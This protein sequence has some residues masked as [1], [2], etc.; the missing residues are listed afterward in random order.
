MSSNVI[1]KVARSWLGTPYRH[2]AHLKGVGTDC[3]GLIC[4]VWSELYGALPEPLPAYTAD[5]AEALKQETLLQAARRHLLECPIGAAQSGDVLLFRLGLGHP[6]KHCAILTEPGQIIHAYWGRSVC[7]TRLVP[8]WQRRIAGAF[9]FPK[10]LPKQ[11]FTADA[12]SCDV[13]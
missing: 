11:S 12:R 6:A 5:W 7:E 9:R 1:V 2:Q 8:W 10:P 4:G 3:L 13:E